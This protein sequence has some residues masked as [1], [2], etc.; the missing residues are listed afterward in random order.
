MSTSVILTRR[1]VAGKLAILNQALLGN[2][3]RRSQVERRR[4]V[5]IMGVSVKKAE[6]PL[7]ASD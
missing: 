5:S 7:G 2:R 3:D 1:D 6:T 4:T